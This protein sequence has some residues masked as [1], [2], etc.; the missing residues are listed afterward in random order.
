MTQSLPGQAPPVGTPAP[1]ADPAP[2]GKSRVHDT[3]VNAAAGV[4]LRALPRIPDGVKRLLLGRRSVT[5]DGNTLDT[6]LQ[7]MLAGQNAAGIGRLVISDDVFVARAHLRGVTAH[8]NTDIRV[9]VTDLSVPG[10]AGP[11]PVRHY[12][13]TDAGAPLLVFYHGGGFA[14]RPRDP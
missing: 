11:I 4:T 3:V 1:G 5:V 7:L 8:L 9:V 2:R 6:T 12:R 13:A 14:L 10:P